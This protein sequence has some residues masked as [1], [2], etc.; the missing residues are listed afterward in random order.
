MY[1]FSRRFRA[2]RTA[3]RKTIRLFTLLLRGDEEE[4]DHPESFEEKE[5]DHLNLDDEEDDDLEPPTTTSDD[6]LFAYHYCRYGEVRATVEAIFAE[7]AKMRRAVA[8]RTSRDTEFPQ[9]TIAYW[10]R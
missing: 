1:A 3:N 8:A 5:D 9:S 4:K 2:A 10:R 6:P 7:C